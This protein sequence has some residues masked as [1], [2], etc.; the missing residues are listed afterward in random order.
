[1]SFEEVIF[2]L[3]SFRKVSKV[4]FSWKEAGNCSWKEAGNGNP[5]DTGIVWLVKI[6]G[7]IARLVLSTPE[8]S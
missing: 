2:R 3:K 1:M 4:T 8:T 7:E 6:A 5:R